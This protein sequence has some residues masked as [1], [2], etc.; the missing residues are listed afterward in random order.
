MGQVEL[1][2][3]H[4]DTARA[5]RTRYGEDYLGAEIDRLEALLQQQED[6]PAEIVERHLINALETAR[7]QSARLLELR[8]ASTLAQ[9]LAERNERQKAAD[10][11]APIYRWFTEGYDTPDLKKARSLVD[12]LT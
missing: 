3:S 6:A 1:T 5:H 7:R 2:R 12:D 8:A 10:F 4:L 9:I 11:L